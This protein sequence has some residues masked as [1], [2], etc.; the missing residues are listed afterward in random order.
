MDS[1]RKAEIHL[2]ELSAFV[3]GALAA[4]HVLGVIYNVKK[5]NRWDIL[6]HTAAALYDINAMHSHLAD[7][8]E[9]EISSSS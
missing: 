6:A 5:R 8:R 1:N 9:L 2:A 4:F 3:H 7:V